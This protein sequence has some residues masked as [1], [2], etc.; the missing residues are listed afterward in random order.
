MVSINYAM[1]QLILLI[2]LEVCFNNI[3]T[4]ICKILEVLAFKDLNFHIYPK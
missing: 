4:L 1:K 3:I 2:I